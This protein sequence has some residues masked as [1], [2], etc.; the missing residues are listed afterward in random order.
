MVKLEKMNTKLILDMIEEVKQMKFRPRPEKSQHK[1]KNQEAYNN[2][3]HFLQ[4]H[5]PIDVL[6]QMPGETENTIREFSTVYWN[7]TRP[8]DYSGHYSPERWAQQAIF[9]FGYLLGME[10]AKI[11]AAQN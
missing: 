7:M 1:P 2:A 4:E 10:A 8:E 6:D 11:A 3:L 9:A 5:E